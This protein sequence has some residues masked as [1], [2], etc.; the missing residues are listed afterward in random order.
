MMGEM[1]LNDCFEKNG[2]KNDQDSVDGMRQ[3]VD[4]TGKVM[5]G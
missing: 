2:R 5:C 4:S 1:N 3:E